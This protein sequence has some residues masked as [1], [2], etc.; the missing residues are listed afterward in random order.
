M[1]HRLGMASCKCVQST[2][3]V[4]T[5]MYIAFDAYFNTLLDMN[6]VT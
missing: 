5:T 3:V 1:S 4:R 6:V 2:I